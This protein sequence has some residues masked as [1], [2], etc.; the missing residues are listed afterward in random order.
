M[1]GIDGFFSG[2]STA[3]VIYVLIEVN[4]LKV[5]IRNLQNLVNKLLNKELKK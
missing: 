4:K 3:L 1:N 5:E 2:L